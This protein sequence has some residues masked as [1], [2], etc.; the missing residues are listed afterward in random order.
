M[1]RTR[2][3][4]CSG[5]EFPCSDGRGCVARPL[6][7]DDGFHCPDGSD[8][9]EELCEDVGVIRLKESH[10]RLEVLGMVA[11]AVEVKRRGVW[12]A[13]CGFIAISDAKVL[14]RSLG[15]SSG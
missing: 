13:V 15:Y 9:K 14:C 10:R 3:S 6:V 11:G 2:H 1:C 5:R 12:A 4:K 7:C 8:E